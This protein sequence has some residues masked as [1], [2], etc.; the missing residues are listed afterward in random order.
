MEWRALPSVDWWIVIGA[1]LWSILWVTVVY[2]LLS[3]LAYLR[4][5]GPLQLAEQRYASGE[6]GRE[7]FER[8]RRDPG[9]TPVGIR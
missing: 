7:G 9:D 3:T 5:P 1:V 2:L 6:I 8:A 4:G